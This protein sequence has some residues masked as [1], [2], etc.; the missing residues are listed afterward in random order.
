MA[1]LSSTVKH[2]WADLRSPLSCVWHT[3]PSSLPKTTRR[4]SPMSAAQGAVRQSD[5]TATGV[6]DWLSSSSLANQLAFMGR[7][8]KKFRSCSHEVLTFSDVRK[9]EWTVIASEHSI[10]NIQF[11]L[12]RAAI[13]WG[14]S[15]CWQV[16]YSICKIM[17][18]GIHIFFLFCLLTSPSFILSYSLSL[19]VAISL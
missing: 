7:A 10:Q 13:V 3:G 18:G 6:W 16:H 5:W 15:V 4:G 8:K 17:K 19:S 14:T 9:Q 12:K 1:H 2:R 11:L